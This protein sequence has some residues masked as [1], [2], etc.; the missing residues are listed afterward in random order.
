[1]DMGS[2]FVEKV[3]V[4]LAKQVVAGCMECDRKCVEDGFRR[5][6]FICILNAYREQHP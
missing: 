5:A 4:E 2:D 1:M 3:A 6:C